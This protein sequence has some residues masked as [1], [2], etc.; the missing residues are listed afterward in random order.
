LQVDALDVS[1]YGGTGISI[2]TA[3]A[4]AAVPALAAH[5][6]LHSVS[7]QPLFR[8]VAGLDQLSGAGDIGIVLEAKGASPNEL[9]GSVSGNVSL[10]LT[11]GALGSA[12]L[13]ELMQSP[14]KF[15][16]RQRHRDRRSTPR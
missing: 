11:N 12:G 3:D 5:A 13:S 6:D 10:N 4:G 8:D 9:V 1:L 14:G 15:R 2:L 16:G 7:V